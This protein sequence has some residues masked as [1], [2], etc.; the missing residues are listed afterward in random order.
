M[1]ARYRQLLDSLRR[2]FPQP[3]SDPVHDAYFV[4]TI[5]RALAQVDGLKSQTPMLGPPDWPDFVSA[6]RH[7][8]ETAG[9]PLE[10][11]V[12]D[13][14]EHLKGMFI[15]GHPQ[16]QINVVSHPSIASVIGVLLP[17]TYNPNLCS[18]ESGR[19][20]SEAEVRATAMLAD[21]VG[22]DSQ[23]AAGVFTFGGTGGMLY[24]VRAGLEKALPG[25]MQHG[26]RSDAVIIASEA[27]HHAVLNV[28]GWLGIG[29]DHV[30]TVP[31]SDDNAIRLELLEETLRD[32]LARDK[33]I[34]AIVATMGSTD[35]F[36][37]DDVREIVALRDSLAA[38]MGLNYLPHVHAD[39]VIGWAWSVFSDYD[40]EN[41]DLGFRG[42]TKRALFAANHRIRHLSLA[43]SIAVDF[44][45]TGYCPFISSLVVFK[46][47]GDLRLLARDRSAMPY[48]FQSGSHHPGMYTLETSRGGA[49]PMAALANLLFLGK[50]GLR[51]LLGHAVEMAEVLRE[52][53]E[54]HPDLTL[55]N[56]HNVGAVTLFRMYPKGVDTY[57]VKAREFHDPDY[58]DQ[59]LAVNDYNR[60]IYQKVHAEALTGKGVVLSMTDCYR[61]TD[62]GNPVTALKSYVLS[63]FSDEERMHSILEHVLAA[64]DAIEAE[65][66]AGG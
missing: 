39:A 14:V 47:A 57:T 32:V 20:V 6:R 11:V 43:D 10:S 15:W 27:S 13:L 16:S 53:I 49:G 29:Q 23:Q 1:S 44:H 50:E 52:G 5:S 54:S 60:R 55:L 22:Y 38:E 34:A 63:P 9:R 17:S 51:V 28:A 21:L 45:K 64:R 66:A 37:I 4:F 24:G 62:S 61:L 56:E 58:Q 25:S 65:Q 31:T 36:G 48:V 18:E 7:K 42:R 40:F 59:V 3:V 41:N 46:T 2:G 19:G 12:G 35:A 26:V 30:I 33:K 8:V